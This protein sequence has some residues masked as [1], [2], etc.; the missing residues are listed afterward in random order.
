VDAIQIIIVITI[1]TVIGTIIIDATTIL[2]LRKKE[3]AIV[4]VFAMAVTVRI[5][6]GIITTIVAVNQKAGG[7]PVHRTRLF[8]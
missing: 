6:S 7:Y 3:D 2:V 1:A 4:K 8:T 5:V